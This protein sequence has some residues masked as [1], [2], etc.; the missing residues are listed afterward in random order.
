MQYNPSSP[1]DSSQMGRQGGSGSR[2]S[3]GRGGTVALSGGAGL[4][5]IVL[6]LVFGFDPSILLQEAATGGAAYTN[7]DDTYDD[8]VDGA[9]IEQHRECRYVA[10]TNSIQA[11]WTHALPGYQQAQTVTFTG[12]TSTAC[13]VATSAV[14]PFYCSADQTIYLDTGFFDGMLA[15]LGAQGGDAA[16]A[17]VVAHEYGHHVQELTGVLGQVQAAGQQTGPTSPQVRLELQADCYA[18]VWFAHAD[19]DPNGP[20]SGVTEDDLARAMDAAI[21]V[22]DDRIQEQSNGKVSPES[23][24]HGS[25]AQR[26]EWLSVGFTTGDPNQCATFSADALE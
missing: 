21:A 17:Y 2:G 9:S 13:G 24:T 5:I 18:G 15:R 1:L 22:G 12:Q 8:C 7:T 23:W 20:I 25:S 16:E 4:L 10:Y 19:A 6:A 3:G 26:R 11:Y 14:G